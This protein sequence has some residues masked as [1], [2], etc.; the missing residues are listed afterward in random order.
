MVT[1]EWKWLTGNL[2]LLD[3]NSI[4]PDKLFW[5]KT[6]FSDLQSDHLKLHWYMTKSWFT[7]PHLKG[8]TLNLSWV[9]NGSEDTNSKFPSWHTCAW[10]SNYITRR[11][12]SRGAQVPRLDRALVFF[13]IPA[14]CQHAPQGAAGSSTGGHSRETL[15]RFPALH[16]SL[17][18]SKCC[19]LLGSKLEGRRF[20]LSL[21]SGYVFQIYNTLLKNFQLGSGTIV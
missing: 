20:S 13:L 2:I 8:A 17:F 21:S 9:L 10:H 3:S 5:N 12:V 14:A 1:K 15:E 16:F 11:D 7:G 19:C 18:S 6:L 4:S